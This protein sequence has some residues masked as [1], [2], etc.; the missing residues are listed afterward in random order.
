MSKITIQSIAK[1]M[2]LSRNTVSL[3]LKGSEL[4][5]PHTIDRVL[6][7]AG[8]IGYLNIEQPEESKKP[9]AK[10]ALQVMILCKTDLAVFWDKIIGGITAEAS[11]NNFQT[12]V[13]VITPV[14]EQ[15]LQL[16]IGLNKDIKAV[17]CVKLFSREYMCKIR[18]MGIMIFTLDS[19]ADYDGETWGDI[20]KMESYKAVQE[21]VQHLIGRGIRKIGFLNEHSHTY[22]TMHDRY[23]GFIRG[24]ECAGLALDPIV[25]FPNMECDN[26]YEIHTFERFVENIKEMP[27]AIVCGNDE[28]AK[29][30]TQSL[31]N[32]GYQVPQDVAVTGFDNDEEGMI[33]P[34]FTTV[35][36]DVK[37]M[38]RRMVQCFL[39]R[40]ACPDAPFEKIVISGKV[41]I[42]KSS[43]R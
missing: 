3:A 35:C 28:I 12:Q 31:R 6:K 21:I 30:L 5:S 1:D 27:E 41:I 38:G 37:W 32:K 40:L 7:Y 19:Y 34:F 43:L 2:G 17:F 4:V 36:M 9:E 16:P 22:E 33:N 18:D 26:F 8:K 10:E 15:S 42:R 25:I 24:I 11:A 14:M 39:K 20:V 23:I 29:F 13:S